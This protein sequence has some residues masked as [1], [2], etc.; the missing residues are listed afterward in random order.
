MSDHYFC[1]DDIRA[2]YYTQTFQVTHLKNLTFDSRSLTVDQEAKVRTSTVV[3]S[4]P[5]LPFNWSQGRFVFVCEQV[6]AALAAR[7]L[8]QLP[9]LRLF[10]ASA[11]AKLMLVLLHLW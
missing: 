10:V 8:K 9:E 1:N 2:H 4:R 7:G 5:S 3:E 6:V 11:G